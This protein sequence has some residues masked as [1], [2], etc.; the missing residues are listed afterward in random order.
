M[1]EKLNAIPCDGN[2]VCIS[3]VWIK[4]A[5]PNKSPV[6]AETLNQECRHV[7]DMDFARYRHFSELM[8]MAIFVLVYRPSSSVERCDRHHRP[9]HGVSRVHH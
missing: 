8:P 5:M 6:M 4:R 2:K 1:R 7:F 9:R 3:G